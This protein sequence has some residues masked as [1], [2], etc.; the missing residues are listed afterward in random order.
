[1]SSLDAK[2]TVDRLGFFRI[3]GAPLLRLLPRLVLELFKIFPDGRLVGIPEFIRFAA[4]L[5]VFAGATGIQTTLGAEDNGRLAV[6]APR[7]FEFANCFVA[8]VLFLTSSPR[9]KPGDS[10]IIN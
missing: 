3:L 7:P 8:T 9:L 6:E 2:N 1:M 10:S 4:P 5:T